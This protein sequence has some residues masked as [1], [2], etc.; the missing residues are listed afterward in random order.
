MGAAVGQ[1]TERGEIKGKKK[2]RRGREAGK[3]VEHRRRRRCGT[4]THT[5]TRDRFTHNRRGWQDVVTDDKASH[6]RTT[7]PK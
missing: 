7:A 2:V 3:A 6:T 4:R 1:K 5:H